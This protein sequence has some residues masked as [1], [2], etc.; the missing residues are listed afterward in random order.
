MLSMLEV[1]KKK[2]VAC[3]DD[4]LQDESGAGIAF[5]NAGNVRK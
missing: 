3:F 2:S 4:L 1:K 5:I